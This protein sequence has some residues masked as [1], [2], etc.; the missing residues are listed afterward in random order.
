[1]GCGYDEYNIKAAIALAKA[2]DFPIEHHGCV[3]SNVCN[4]SVSRAMSCEEMH[5][6]SIALGVLPF[7]HESGSE[8]D[9][10]ELLALPSR[11]QREK[12]R[13]KRWIFDSGC[14]VDLVSKKDIKEQPHSCGGTTYVPYS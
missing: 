14:G 6:V 13:I 4:S 7:D 11:V 1:M 8:N 3:P 5:N 9:E 10:I 2:A 12:P